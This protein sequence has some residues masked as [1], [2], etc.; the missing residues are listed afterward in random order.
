[1]MFDV[2]LLMALAV[3]VL[4]MLLLGR[5]VAVLSGEVAEALQTGDRPP[6]NV[7]PIRRKL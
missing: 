7:V 4:V 3:L 5:A 1:M 2:L 6:D